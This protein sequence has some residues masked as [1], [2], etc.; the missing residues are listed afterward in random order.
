MVRLHLGTFNTSRNVAK[1]GIASALGA[2]DRQFKSGHSDLLPC[3]VTAA[4][5]FLELTEQ[6]SIPSGAIY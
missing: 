5:E 2:E 3:G 1:F 4:H 6:G